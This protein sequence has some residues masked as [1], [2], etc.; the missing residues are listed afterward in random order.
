MGLTVAPL[1]EVRFGEPQVLIDGGFVTYDNASSVYVVSP[2]A[3]R[4]L[5][6]R[7]DDAER[8][9]AESPTINT[10]LNWFDELNER[11]SV[12]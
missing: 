2:T 3:Q 12:P 8:G 5:R 11:A 10:V 7:A 1:P 6:I 4:F 9:D